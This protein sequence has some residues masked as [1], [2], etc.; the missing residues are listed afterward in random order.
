MWNITRKQQDEFAVSSQ[1][2]AQNAIKNNKFR[3]ELI[4]NNFTDEHPRSD[5]T[6]EKFFKFK[7]SFKKWNCYCW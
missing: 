2:K 4:D 7:D 3:D 6:L 5:V 1:H